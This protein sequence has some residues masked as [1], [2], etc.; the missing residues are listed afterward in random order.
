MIESFRLFDNC[1]HAVVVKNK[2]RGDSCVRGNTHSGTVDKTKLFDGTHRKYKYLLNRH[3]LYTRHRHTVYSYSLT[4]IS[5]CGAY[6]VRVYSKYRS[7]IKKRNSFRQV[8]CTKKADCLDANW[9]E[10]FVS[11][12]YKQ[13]TGQLTAIQQ[14]DFKRINF[15]GSNFQTNRL[16]SQCTK[17]IWLG[18]LLVYSTKLSHMR[19]WFIRV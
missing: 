18:S 19:L 7:V 14:N 11:L 3:T 17:M 8:Q 12:R 9:M 4:V 6:N 16:T 15:L 13:L 2:W 1:L 10:I 5:A